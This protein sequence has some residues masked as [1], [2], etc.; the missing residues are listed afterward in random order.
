[1]FKIDVPEMTVKLPSAG[2]LN[3]PAEVR[4]RAITGKEELKMNSTHIAKYI[5]LVIESCV[6]SLDESRPFD[7]KQLTAADKVY[8]FIMLRSLSYGDSMNVEYMCQSCKTINN[9]SIQLSDLPVDYLTSEMAENLVITLPISKFII[10]L[11]NITDTRLNELEL[12]ARKKS[13]QSKRN[14]NE[15]RELLVSIER[16]ESVTYED[17]E[18]GLMVEENTADN[19]AIFQLLAEQLV[20]RDLAAIQAAWDQINNYGIT[21]YVVHKCTNCGESSTIGVDLTSTEFFR[22]R[23]IK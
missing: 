23:E 16:I 15:E 21:P 18:R 13:M 5:D 9:T 4:L 12:E 8:I 3:V 7:F 2:L 11:R 6:T 20:G 14:F 22:P 1:M 10:K 17:D 19:R